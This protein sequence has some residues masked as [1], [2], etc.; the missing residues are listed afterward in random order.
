MARTTKWAREVPRHADSGGYGER[1]SA[2]PLAVMLAATFAAVCV[3]CGDSAGDG[4]AGG[5]AGRA[6][7][8][9]SGTDGGTAGNAAGGGGMGGGAPSPSDL[10]CGERPGGILRET[11][12]LRFESSDGSEVVQIRRVFEDSGAGESSIYRL[13]SFGL[14]LAEETLCIEDGAALEYVNTH[15]NWSDVARASAGGVHYELRFDFAAGESLT[16]TA[17]DG[18]VVLGPQPVIWTGAPPFCMNCLE[19][20]GAGISELMTNNVSVHADEAGEFEPWLELY[21]PSSEDID[22]TGWTLSNDFRNRRK[23]T[24]PAVTL[25]RHRTLLVIADGDTEQGALH[26]NFRLSAGGGEI[27][28][29]RPDG[30][31][32]G[33]FVYG[34]QSADESLVFEYSAAGYVETDSPTPGAPQ[35][36]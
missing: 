17:D 33:G 1:G 31:T 28:L 2:G 29:T 9:G 34:S 12:V 20:P 23:W 15:H 3:A 16:A 5:G 6:G 13:E 32:D 36:E 11:H 24:L 14:R 8:G 27:V 30:V 26:A 35:P 25:P 21:N 19:W 10:L 18:S 7:S 4:A 22:L